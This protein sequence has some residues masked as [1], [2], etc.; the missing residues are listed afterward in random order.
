MYPLIRIAG[1]DLSTYALMALV[2]ALIAG[3]FAEHQAVKKGAHPFYM[4]EIL[5]YGVIGIFIGGHLLYGIV[6]IKEIQDGFL[7]AF[8]GQVFYGGLLGALAIG[9]FVIK[10]KGYPKALYYD[11]AACTIPLFH[12]FARIGCFLVGCC[13]GV[14]SKYGFTYT[15]AL[16]QS[17]NGVSR[18][19]VQ[20]LESFLNFVLFSVLYALLKKERCIGS[21]LWIYL[22]SYAAMRFCLEML[23]GDDVLRGI[24]LGLSTSQWIS[25]I[26]LLAVSL[27]AF[28]R[29]KIKEGK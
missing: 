14:E 23:R 4:I 11:V 26:I 22:G 8:G 18:F 12:G 25:L 7:Q 9:A 15:E 10:K 20:L 2:G 27:R 28:Y 5:L 17:A 29:G 3:S 19:P 1:N 6:H 16:I 24:W 13:Y 21:L